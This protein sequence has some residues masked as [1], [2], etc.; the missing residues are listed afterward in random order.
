[1]GEARTDRRDSG[2]SLG[3]VT[4]GRPANH[5]M[6]HA[7]TRKGLWLWIAL[8]TIAPLAVYWQ[9][10]FHEYG[11]R[12]DYS[13][14]RESHEEP[15]KLFRITTANGR[16]IYGAVLEASL[17]PLRVIGDLP[18]LRLLAVALLASVAVVLWRQLRRSGWSNLE[19]GA[20]ALGVAL[21]PGAQITVG[22]AIAW[23]IALAL[24]FAVVGF[25]V[26][27]EGL[28]RTDRVHLPSLALG[29]AFYF[30]A[31]LTYQSSALFAAVPIAAAL[32]LR[33]DRE[34]LTHFRWIVLHLGTLLASLLAAFLLI[35]FVFDAGCADATRAGTVHE[36]AVVRAPTAREFA[37]AVRVAR[38][39]PHHRLLLGRRELHRG[40]AGERLFLWRAD[41]LA[42]VAVVILSALPAV[43]RA[44][45]EPRGEL[46]GD[47]LP[48]RI[49][50]VRARARA[51]RVRA[52]R[53]LRDSQA[54]ARRRD[55]G[56][57][58]AIRCR[59]ALRS[60][61]RVRADRRAAG[62]R[63]GA[64]RRGR[65]EVAARRGYRRLHHSARH[66]RPLDR[67]SLRRRVRV[68]VVGCGLGVARDVQGCNARALP[69]ASAVGLV[70]VDHH[71]S[72]AAS[73]AERVR[74]GR[75]LAQA[76][77]RGRPA[78]VG[79]CGGSD[80]GLT[81]LSRGSRSPPISRRSR[82]RVPCSS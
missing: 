46:A 18:W 27:E 33:D 59:C 68:A 29:G 37:R 23:P 80:Y 21:L 32:L 22:W 79:G 66:R 58:V 49:R 38:P 70:A 31:G 13:L 19:A 42:E 3:R 34:R 81:P 35:R 62:A 5:A 50:L 28:R 20:I 53:R 63:V 10:V 8:L 47:R 39:L 45:G 54:E 26:V 72:G 71:R 17:R 4:R 36:A 44:R 48:H 55:G 51:R 57:R 30:L 61:Q 15:F 73:L 82:P 64:H 24:L 75:R 12:D 77:P 67:A 43:R 74:R 52:A 69:R 60:P 56:V 14:L 9:T 40:G 6:T 41:P 76:A 78:V 25:S 11:F 16:P 7:I 65:Q 1:M 2:R